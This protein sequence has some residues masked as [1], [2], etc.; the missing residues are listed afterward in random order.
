M[1]FTKEQQ[2]AIT[3]SGKNI[4]VSAGA[5][6]GKTEVLKQ[7]VTH[8]ISQ[9]NGPKLNQFLILTFTNLAAGEM[10]DRI[11]KALAK[12]KSPEAN[13][14]DA[15]DICTFDAYALSLVKK[16]HFLLK[17]SPNVSN[18]DSTIIDV[19]KRTII[20]EIFENYYA[21]KEPRFIF[22]IDSL[23]FKNDK[24]VKKM[25]L[26]VYNKALLELDTKEYLST[27][28]S[29]YYNDDLIEEMVSS[30]ERKIIESK[31]ELVSMINSLSTKN[32]PNGKKGDKEDISFRNKA[33]EIF[34]GLG[35]KNT[36]DEVVRTFLGFTETLPGMG[37]PATASNVLNEEEATVLES[38]HDKYKKLKERADA[39][40]ATREE[41]KDYLLMSKPFAEMIVDILFELDERITKYKQEKNAFEFNDI[42]KMALDLVKNHEEVREP[43]KN[44]LKMIMVDEY[45]DTS[46]LQDKFISYISNNNVYMVG[47][48]KQSIY[49]FRNADVSIFI[50][51]YD[52]YK[53]HDAESV[54][55]MNT[56]FRSRP[57]ILSGINYMFKQIMTNKYGGADYKASHLIEAGNKFYDRVGKND[58]QSPISYLLYE[59]GV[60]TKLK[61]YLEEEAHVI[62]RDII[63]KINSKFQVMD[64]R[65]GS[66][67]KLLEDEKGNPIP[68]LRDCCFTDFCILMDR[69]GAFEKYSRVFSSYNLPLYVEN[70][71]DVTTNDMVLVMTNVLRL[72]KCIK[73]GD[74]RSSTFEKALASVARSYIFGKKDQDL[75][76]M[77]KAKE[78]WNKTQKELKKRDPEY[79]EP[80]EGPFGGNEIV[81]KIKEVILNNYNSSIYE[82]FEKI[83]FKLEFY[84][85]CL[86]IGDVESNEKYLDFFLE[87]F[88]AMSELDYSIDDFII[89]MECVDEYKLK[90]KL[91]SQ[92]SSLDS[93][94]IM[95]YHKSKGL[96]FNIVYYSGLKKQFN[97]EE[98]KDKF[99]FSS[100]Y[101]LITPPLLLGKAPITKEL[102][103]ELENEEDT[104]E[105]IRQ[106][107]VALT[108]AREEAIILLPEGFQENNEF[109]E[110]MDA[111]IKEQIES[112]TSSLDPKEAKE[113]E[114]FE[115]VFGAYRKNKINKFAFYKLLR[116]YGLSMP[117]EFE[118]DE[119]LLEN[120]DYETYKATLLENDEYLLKITNIIGE[121][122]KTCAFASEVVEAAYQKYREGEI[123]NLYDFENV[124]AEKGYELTDAFFKDQTLDDNDE[125]TKESLES[126]ALFKQ[127]WVSEAWE[128]TYGAGFDKYHGFF[129]KLLT[130]FA[131]GKIKLNDIDI[132]ASLLDRKLDQDIH[133]SLED[134]LETYDGN[135]KRWEREC[136]YSPLLEDDY[137]KDNDSEKWTK[138]VLKALKAALEGELIAKEVISL[139]FVTTFKDMPFR[140]EIKNA[141]IMLRKNE[142]TDDVFEEFFA[143]TGYE[144]SKDTLETIHQMTPSQDKESKNSIFD[145][146]V[147]RTKFMMTEKTLDPYTREESFLFED[148]LLDEYKRYKNGTI[149][150]DHLLS[151]IS[152]LGF[153]PTIVFLKEDDTQRKLHNDSDIDIIF[154]EKG[155]I[156]DDM[157]EILGF[158][159]I[160]KLFI[161]YRKFKKY[162]VDAYIRKPALVNP[163]K[164][165]DHVKL[166]PENHDI[167]I[168]EIEMFHPS[169]KLDLGVK[170]E[171]LDFGTRM[172]FLMEITDFKSPDYSSLSDKE[173]AT[174]KKFLSS[175]LMKD[176]QEGEAYK[177]YEFFDEESNLRGI[178][179]LMMVYED[180]IDIIDYKTKKIDDESYDK[181]VALYMGVASKLFGKPVKGYLYSLIEGTCREVTIKE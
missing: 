35:S 50:D 91:S 111:I 133:S 112:V 165:V 138:G 99:G 8:F 9:E 22:M 161:G 29:R 141:I 25:I 44:K 175:D 11:R 65:T 153:E 14:V 33:A 109:E 39:L 55:D 101:G 76:E 77:F 168:K 17:V 69:G 62:A 163:P 19:R 152:C 117:K 149:D 88:K 102:N 21:K 93:V 45:Q 32:K 1:E 40:P 105:K 116:I 31:N 114:A 83:C 16:Y 10:K 53:A 173:K 155:Q 89:F 86:E 48:V 156:Y 5:G 60:N 176:V 41:L 121:L 68:Y 71:D 34:D 129:V 51:K 12:I 18:I 135:L 154:E 61:D 147:F 136:K 20:D 113:P 142:I 26:K 15:A 74:Y 180:H 38:F 42:A 66:D 46:T 58:G 172:H 79:K 115:A 126:N 7:R 151:L 139:I 78:E 84:G 144:C 124:I 107:Y 72:I 103:S 4:L 148:L 110:S 43:I 125:P 59:E 36:Y 24:D 108:R 131:K 157:N 85:K 73:E 75:F 97:R 98:L 118:N 13:E 132:I 80:L 123:E 92:G 160:A 140:E 137:L 134:F 64:Y 130:L 178:I 87:K 167:Q 143:L 67:G 150:Y 127:E 49:R 169:K 3:R 159:D 52:S 96:E 56:N 6:S 104:S 81:T 106:F 158:S 30:V 177:E 90:L 128:L 100:K 170:K 162:A 23:C 174:V 54:I 47:D 95:N 27:F 146:D 171:A 164:E 70:D 145:V 179:D 28:V 119:F 82:I 37:L 122:E 63:S 57:E 2:A 166:E 181:Q 120:A 94:T